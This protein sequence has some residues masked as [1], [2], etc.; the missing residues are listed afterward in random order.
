MITCKHVSL[1][2]GEARR[3]GSHFR[4]RTPSGRFG[5]GPLL[6]RLGTRMAHCCSL[7]LCLELSSQTPCF[8]RAGPFSRI[9]ALPEERFPDS[10]QPNYFPLLLPRPD[11]RC[12]SRLRPNLRDISPRSCFARRSRGRNHFL[13]KR[14]VLVGPLSGGRLTVKYGEKKWP[15]RPPFPA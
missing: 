1:F 9:F 12:F 2:P 3:R 10:Y 11:L 14:Q 8:S 5:N 6:P 13:A 4:G 7:F 15:C